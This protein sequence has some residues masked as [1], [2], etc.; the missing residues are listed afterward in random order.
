[1]IDTGRVHVDQVKRHVFRVR[2][3]RDSSR[4]LVSHIDQSKRFLERPE[5]C[6]SLILPFEA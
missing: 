5:S 4:A 1:M 6:C 2:L 3:G